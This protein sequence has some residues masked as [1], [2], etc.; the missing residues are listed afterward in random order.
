V[1]PYRPG[2]A[3]R[4]AGN[5]VDAPPSLTL[6]PLVPPSGDAEA[7]GR[8][9]EQPSMP[10]CAPSKQ[11]AVRAP[12]LMHAI[13]PDTR[14]VVAAA[15]L[16]HVAEAE[17]DCGTP[18]PVA[19]HGDLAREPSHTDGGGGGV[20]GGSSTSSLS[21][22]KGS[23][24]S[25]GIAD[26]HVPLHDVEPEA[27]GFQYAYG[28]EPADGTSAWDVTVRFEILQ[29]AAGRQKFARAPSRLVD[30]SVGPVHLLSNDHLYQLELDIVVNSRGCAPV[31]CEA[32]ETGPW[33][34]QDE[35]PSD[36]KQRK[37]V[38]NRLMAHKVSTSPVVSCEAHAPNQRLIARADMMPPAAF[39]R[40]LSTNGELMLIP[41]RFRV[42]FDSF[43]SGVTMRA[44]LAVHVLPLGALPGLPDVQPKLKDSPSVQRTASRM[45]AAQPLCVGFAKRLKVAPLCSSQGM[46]RALLKQKK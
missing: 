34:H 14:P 33:V 18:E 30:A 39:K 22:L 9:A 17:D 5:V 29:S 37:L 31:K 7:E 15:A 41:L 35:Y 8:G 20:G 21:R 10:R 1:S 13:D 44:L 27:L 6:P 24:G 42:V 43:A 11:W 16:A 45:P 19:T 2:G 38:F 12:P 28:A 4:I 32:V 36:L 26:G 3:R 23:G 46:Y 25:S 40:F